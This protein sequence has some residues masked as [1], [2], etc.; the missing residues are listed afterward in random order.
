[1]I[2]KLVR[3]VVEN[4]VVKTTV[5]PGKKKVFGWF[6]GAIL[7]VSD[8]TGRKLIERGDAIEHSGTA[9]GEQS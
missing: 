8:A 5:R 4:G 6:E 1:M 9:E 2:I 3:D 7:D